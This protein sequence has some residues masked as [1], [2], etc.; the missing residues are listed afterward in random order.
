MVT[1][2]PSPWSD[3]SAACTSPA[4]RPTAS[5]LR[6]LPDAAAAVAR[7]RCTPD[8]LDQPCERL[9]TIADDVAGHSGHGGTGG[10]P[11]GGR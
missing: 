1:T 4:K 8:L 5:A 10:H 9:A 11:Q 2:R 7:C 3:K 6:T